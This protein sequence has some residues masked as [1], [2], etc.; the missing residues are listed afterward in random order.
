MDPI[1]TIPSVK[2]ELLV[3]PTGQGPIVGQT[4]FRLL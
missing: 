4:L 3:L 2:G 1:E